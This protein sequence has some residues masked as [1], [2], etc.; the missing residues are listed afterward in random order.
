MSNLVQTGRYAFLSLFYNGVKVDKDLQDDLIS[1]TYNDGYSGQADDI[2]I[3]LDDRESRWIHGW[4]PVMGDELKTEIVTWHWDKYKEKKK[5][6]CGKFYLKSFTYDG[7]PN[8]VSMEASALPVE[9][10]K[11]K[12]EKRSKSWEKIKLKTVAAEI[13]ARGKLS[14][15][16]EASFNP[17][18]DRLDMTDQTDF[19]FLL[20]LAVNEGITL[21]VSGAKLVLFDEEEY[22]KA[23]PAL[24]ITYGKSNIISYSFE[25]NSESSAYGSCEV[26]YTAPKTRN[27]KSKTIKGSYKLANAAD[28]PVLRIN[29]SISSEAEANRLAKKKLRAENKKYGRAQ[30]TLE[31]T[32]EI[33]A[34]STVS[35]KGF[36]CFDG[37]Y[38]IESATHQ[39]SATSPY[40]TSINIRKVLGW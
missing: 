6:P 27:S 10:N 30:M 11:S 26:A 39:I 36:G 34:G 9:G 22:E 3:Q 2:V 35:I 19:E 16:Y 15:V 29:E 38:I 1:F 4:V 25:T 20:D 23:D 31:G 24:E 13:A 37:K 32:T 40:T 5:L 12:Q 18:Y 21:K 17:S 7:M 14:L 33:T 28:L 8:V